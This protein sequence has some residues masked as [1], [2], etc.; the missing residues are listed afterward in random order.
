[1]ESQL[2]CRHNLTLRLSIPSYIPPLL[3]LYSMFS[4]IGDYNCSFLLCPK[5]EILSVCNSLLQ[6]SIVWCVILIHEQC[7]NWFLILDYIE[8]ANEAI[9]CHSGN[10]TRKG[11]MRERTLALLQPTITYWSSSQN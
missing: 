5:Q 2:Y 4:L 9:P 7:L 10:V 1:M 6:T 3:T 11:E 8:L